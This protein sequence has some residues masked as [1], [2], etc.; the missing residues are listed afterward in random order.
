MLYLNNKPYHPWSEDL[1]G[2]VPVASEKNLW[3]TMDR[4]DSFLSY[5]LLNNTDNFF[6]LTR[7]NNLFAILARER[8]HLR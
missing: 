6:H 5:D 7:I 2:L 8:L 1:A 3:I 4:Y